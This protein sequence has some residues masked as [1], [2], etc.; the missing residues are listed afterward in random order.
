MH[1][2]ALYHRI[3]GW[4]QP[5][6]GLLAWPRKCISQAGV[7]ACLLRGSSASRLCSEV[8]RGKVLG[9]VMGVARVMLTTWQLPNQ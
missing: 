6:P 4:L 2:S 9:G 8:R 3:P 7:G 5:S 1:N